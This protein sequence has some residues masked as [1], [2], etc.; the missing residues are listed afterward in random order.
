MNFY[1]DILMPETSIAN[2]NL[3]YI[4]IDYEPG[5]VQGSDNVLLI[6]SIVAVIQLSLYVKHCTG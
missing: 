3:V 1:C 4:N 6:S 5:G 2:S